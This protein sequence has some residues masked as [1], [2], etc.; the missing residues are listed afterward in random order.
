M[1]P[2][3]ITTTITTSFANEIF[4]DEKTLL[5]DVTS[6][7]YLFATFRVAENGTIGRYRHP[8]RQ[9]YGRIT[10]KSPSESPGEVERRE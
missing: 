1:P 3:P 7:A 2:A 8:P 4:I 6:Y 10:R 9:S 5:K